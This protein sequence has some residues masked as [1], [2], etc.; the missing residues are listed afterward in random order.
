MEAL[1]II[2]LVLGF[3]AG[4]CF[5]GLFSIR[6]IE[7]IE[8]LREET[9]QRALNHFRKLIEIENTIKNDEKNNEYTIYTVRKIKEILQK[10]EVI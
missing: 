7:K 4:L 1:F 6:T 9:E 8:E 2:F 3:G 10:K 5:A